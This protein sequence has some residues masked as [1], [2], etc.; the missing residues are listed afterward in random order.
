MNTL[1][2]HIRD[3]ASLLL[4]TLLFA[5]PAALAA[6]APPAPSAP[7][8]MQLPTPE[9]DQLANG[10][11]TTLVEFGTVPKATIVVVVR[12]GS[13]NQGTQVWL[14]DLVGDLMK[15]GT[16]KRSSEQIANAA[17][18]MGGELGIGVGSEEATLSLDVLSESLPDAVK[19]LAEVL[20]EPLLPESELPRLKQDYLRNLS[21]VRAQAQSQ[22]GN[23]LAKLLYGDHPFGQALPTEEQLASYTIEDVRKFYTANFGAARTHIYVAGRFDRAVLKKSLEAAFGD[24]TRGAEPFVNPPN[25][26]KVQRVQLIDRPGAPQSTIRLA[27]PVISPEHPDFMSM[28]VLNTLLGGSI[29]S[30]ITTNI[31]EEKG[32]AYS[33]SS[34][35]SAR[36]RN[37]I[38]SESADVTTASTGPAI[39][40]VLKEIARLQ[41]TPPTAAELAQVQSYR[42]GLF[43]L[44]NATRG[45]LIGQ[46]TFMDLHG[47]PS[48]WL[49]TFVSRLYAVTPEKVSAMARDQLKMNEAT[50]VVVGDAATV[51]PQLQAV[52]QLQGIRIE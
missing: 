16:R 9:R 14:P 23:A 35:V 45:G 33:P 40:E 36:Y 30:R 17:A 46:L 48:D 13:I 22:A 50:L 11:K 5:G 42:N 24:W 6:E 47:L 34:S 2:L 37:S 31:R 52:P 41:Q 15:E 7:K 12:A 10:L 38:W 43:V 18:L 32:W 8:A 1:R 3:S 51:R 29:T 19:L 21:V 26:S 39:A 20:R 27:L 44:G 28:S 4:A 49:T 25:V